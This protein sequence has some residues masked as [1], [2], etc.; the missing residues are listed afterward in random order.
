MNSHRPGRPADFF[1]CFPAG[2]G[3]GG[4]KFQ[5][6]PNSKFPKSTTVT[7]TTTTKTT[8]AAAAG[9]YTPFFTIIN[10]TLISLFE[11]SPDGSGPGALPGRPYLQAGRWAGR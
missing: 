1:L 3:A 8:T 2:W 9:G 7:T 11:L 4:K 10:T 5:I 6:F